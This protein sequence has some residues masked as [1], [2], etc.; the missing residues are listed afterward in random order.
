MSTCEKQF[1]PAT[2]CPS[3]LM[4]H[5]RV[6]QMPIC[7]VEQKKI[8]RNVLRK[9]KAVQKYGICTTKN[10]FGNNETFFRDM[11]HVRL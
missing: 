9:G 4:Q 3:Q 7:H 10:V 2:T 1:S 5:S 11:I 6:D 8:K